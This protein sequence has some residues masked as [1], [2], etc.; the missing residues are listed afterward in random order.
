MPAAVPIHSIAQHQRLQRLAVIIDQLAGNNH[1]SLVGRTGE[2]LV[3]LKQQTGQFRRITDRR[4]V[5]K[6]I[7]GMVADAR[8]GGVGEDKPHLRVMRQA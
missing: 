2:M 3:T 7:P 4:R 8:L 1:P 6:P 5:V